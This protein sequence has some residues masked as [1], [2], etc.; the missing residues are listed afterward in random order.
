MYLTLRFFGSGRREPGDA[1]AGST[2]FRPLS[3][4]LNR[5]KTVVPL[6][7]HVRMTQTQVRT[8]V[9]EN[10]LS[11]IFREIRRL[12]DEL[13]P[14]AELEERKR[15]LVARFALPL[16]NPTSPVTNELTI[17]SFGFAEDYWESYPVQV[18]AVTAEDVQRV[19]RKY[20]NAEKM[21]IIAVGDAWKIKSALEKYG[22]V[23]TYDINGSRVN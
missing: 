23:E 19:A 15:K 8:D 14:A 2:R 1:G 7:H 20:I 6:L 21:Q 18:M 9:T 13:V 12:S 11:E 3:R 4:P 22:P 10:S 5:L 16:E 17:K